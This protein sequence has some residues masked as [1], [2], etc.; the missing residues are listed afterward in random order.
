VHSVNSKTVNC[1]D[2]LK[3][4]NVS[5][6]SR[7]SQSVL[8]KFSSLADSH[9]YPRQKASL[10][11]LLSKHLFKELFRFPPITIATDKASSLVVTISCGSSCVCFCTALTL[12]VLAAIFPKASAK[13][14]KFYF[15][16]QAFSEE[17]FQKFLTFSLPLR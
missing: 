11:G 17:N 7:N 2:Y 15:L 9:Q 5:F 14:S 6:A 12:L 13:L 10:S 8:T 16:C 4:H 3:E 1:S